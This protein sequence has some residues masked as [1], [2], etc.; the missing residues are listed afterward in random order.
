MLCLDVKYRGD[1]TPDILNNGF[2]FIMGA[3]YLFL[4]L[5]IIKNC[6]IE[7]LSAFKWSV[8]CTKW[9]KYIKGL[10]E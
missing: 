4:I 5:N 3:I 6:N 7:S 10:T 2:N 8:L 9:K 1:K